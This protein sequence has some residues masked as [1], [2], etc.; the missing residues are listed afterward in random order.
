MDDRHDLFSDLIDDDEM[1]EW[2]D[3]DYCII[4]SEKETNDG[5]MVISDN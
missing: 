3:S 1:N 4:R 5:W 2:D